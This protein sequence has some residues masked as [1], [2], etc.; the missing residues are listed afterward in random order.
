MIYKLDIFL[1]ENLESVY[2]LQ[3]ESYSVE[4]KIIKSK[5]LP[6]LLESK[7]DILESDEL[8]WGIAKV[9]KIKAVISV[10]KIDGG[11]RI[12][13]LMVKPSA[14]RMGYGKSLVR[15]VI[16]SYPNQR[17]IVSTAPKNYPACNLYET[18]GFLCL[19]E[20]ETSEGIKVSH[21]VL[22]NS[23]AI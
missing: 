10:D 19:G 13:R 20:E 21:F 17:I 1:N 14:F 9:N 2:K 4:S 18:L 12:C 8:F 23:Q 5:M 6:P 22:N 7:K 15:F 11:V 3:I 16:S